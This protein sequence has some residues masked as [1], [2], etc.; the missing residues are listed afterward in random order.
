MTGQSSKSSEI[1]LNSLPNIDTEI[2]EYIESYLQEMKSGNP[3]IDA[4]QFRDFIV[5]L[6]E[7]F[8]D[9]T[10]LI[11]V[12]CAGL[13]ADSNAECALSNG[14]NSCEDD[15]ETLIDRPILIKSL[16]YSAAAEFTLPKRTGDISLTNASSSR[17]KVDQ[18]KL[19]KAEAKL[20]KKRLQQE[21]V[22]KNSLIKYIDLSEDKMDYHGFNTTVDPRK[23]KGKSKDI[24]LDNFDISFG[25]KTILQNSNLTLAFGR[26]YGGKYLRNNFAIFTSCLIQVIGQNGVGK[27]T[28]LRNIYQRKIVS[29]DK[30]GGI[31]DWLRILLVEQEIT[32]DDTTVLASVLSSDAYQTDLLRQEK[33]LNKKMQEPGITAEEKDKLSMQLKE[34]Y[35]CLVEIEWEKA[36][37]RAALILNG[38]GF[39]NEEMTRPTKLFSGGWRMRIALARALFCKPDVLL[40]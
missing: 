34:V 4:E 39:T 20:E 31:P 25:G 30:N 37:A 28:L 32:G 6:L 10:A 5:P 16:S 7:N 13:L 3:G 24:R 22:A 1:I 17:S 8:T 23:S 27:S 9:D 33:T 29:T 18:K 2:L 36:E 21:T 19:E 38:L 14:K 35:Q 40:W 12:L 15:N 11:D 26:K